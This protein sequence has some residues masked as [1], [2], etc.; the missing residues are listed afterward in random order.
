MLDTRRPNT[1]LFA[2]L[3]LFILISIFSQSAFAY[4]YSID[5][6]GI[7][8][9]VWRPVTFTLNKEPKQAY[10][11]VAFMAMKG[12]KDGD[13]HCTLMKGITQKPIYAS[14]KMD[15]VAMPD[16]EG[17]PRGLTQPLKSEKRDLTERVDALQIVQQ[18]VTWA[19]QQVKDKE[20]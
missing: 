4:T 18:C 3:S 5:G 12:S 8:F 6:R 11:L 19:S 14:T 13:L 17:I 20:D 2:A 7:R 10:V 1:S 9:D 16:L 15:N